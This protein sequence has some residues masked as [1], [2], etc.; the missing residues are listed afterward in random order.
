M[1]NPV[2]WPTERMA[3]WDDEQ[4]WTALIDGAIADPDP[5]NANKR[6][7]LIHREL[8]LALTRIIGAGAGPTYH[9]WAV[10]ASLRAGRTIREEDARWTLVAAPVGAFAAIAAPTAL[11]AAGAGPVTRS[12]GAL[13]LGLLGAFAGWRQAARLMSR[14]SGAILA[15][16]KT[17]IDD[18][19]RQS[20]RFVC[21][22]AR[23]QD[24]NPA[25]LEAFLAPLSTE[26]SAT[27]GQSL[28]RDAY[29]QYFNAAVDSDP[30]R[31]AE[32]LL[33]GAISAVLHEHWR[34]QAYIADSIPRFLRR[35]VTARALSFQI[36]TEVHSVGRDVQG[37]AGRSAFPETLSSIESPE[38]QAFLD[39]WDR[40]PDT[41]VGSAA[42]DWS[43][44]G[45]R[46][47]YIVDLFRSRQNDPGL[48]GP[49][50][51]AA[52]QARILAMG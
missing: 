38:L 40:T 45:D 32:A 31:Q 44:I 13:G 29:R 33:L 4:W 10:W 19:G 26:P 2:G 47:N 12:A 16:N 46:I 24:R 18:L 17:V 28:L 48:L 41:P 8:S 36:G 35:T 1:Q 43:Q 37:P 3:F 6:I 25:T 27:G 22:F 7:T 23:E 50:F 52:E 42:S 39:Q 9:A 51:T 5:A 21:A 15:G 20:A 30:D 14:T 34:L 11:A 49:P